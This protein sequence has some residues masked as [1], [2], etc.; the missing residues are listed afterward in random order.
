MLLRTS[1]HGSKLLAHLGNML[2]PER[3]QKGPR[4]KRR[5]S[6]AGIWYGNSCRAAYSYTTW[7]R[8]AAEICRMTPVRQAM[9][10]SLKTCCPT[11]QI[12]TIHP[13]LASPTLRTPKLLSHPPAG[14]HGHF[15]GF[16][17]APSYAH[18]LGALVA[19]ETYT[20]AFRLPHTSNSWHHNSL[21]PAGPGQGAREDRD[22][23]AVVVVALTNKNTLSAGLRGT[24]TCWYSLVGVKKRKKSKK[25]R[26]TR[27]ETK[28]YARKRDWSS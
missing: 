15:P 10:A 23:E 13:R 17:F 19:P 20:Q 4:T 28:G 1:S 3:A 6:E 27:Q 21:C 9:C 2:S 12:K 11:S 25:R 16:G 24:G 18:T 26:K 22:H 5:Q 7:P 14:P 8:T